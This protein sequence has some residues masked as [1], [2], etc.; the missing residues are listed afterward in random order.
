M[1]GT[2][3]FNPAVLGVALYSAPAEQSG[4]AAGVNDTFRQAGIAVGVAALGALL[5]RRRPWAGGSAQDCVDGMNEALFV[6]GVVA[7]GA[8][9]TALLIGRRSRTTG[10]VPA[11]AAEAAAA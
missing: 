8:V 2:G 9:A 4:L 7:V 5:P 3:M 6:G 10:D 11:I 1:I